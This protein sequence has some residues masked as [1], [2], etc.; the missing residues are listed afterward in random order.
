MKILIA[1]SIHPDAVESLDRNHD[2]KRT[3]NAPEDVLRTAVG[4][5][6]IL[7]FRSGVTVSAAVMGHG[8]KLR[9]LVRA[10]SG[11]D[12]VDVDYAREHGL[13]LVRIPG[14]SAEPV[15]ELTFALLLA[16]ARKVLLADRLIREG[17]WAK[18]DLGGPLL[19]GKTLGIVGAGNIG[20]RVGAMAAAWGMRAIGCVKDP[21]PAVAAT[22]RAKGIAL[23]DFDTVVDEADFLTLHVPLD[24]STRH[25]V[26]ADVISRM[27]P[28]SFVVNMARGGVVDEH[29]LHSALT[30]GGGLAGAAL[31]VHEREGE[32]TVPRLA[33]LPNVVLTP[34]IGAMALDSQRQIGLRVLEIVD[35][36]VRGKLERTTKDGE[37][38]V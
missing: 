35:G 2:V 33:A 15:A 31:D 27:K 9:L 29:A 14:S 38:V 28:G 36:F 21:S 5:R 8:P 17:R 4:D 13:R 32:G 16:V 26:D 20:S 34:H 1:S 12:N 24:E 22:L 23:A 7:I 6:E 25:M 3:L 10:G 18:A 19:A 37:L 30:N 11:L